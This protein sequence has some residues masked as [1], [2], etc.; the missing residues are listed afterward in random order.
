MTLG[1]HSFGVLMSKKTE[2]VEEKSKKKKVKVKKKNQKLV[3][4]STK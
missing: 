4:T 1:G 2:K 3:K